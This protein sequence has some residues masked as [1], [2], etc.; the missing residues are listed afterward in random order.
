MPATIPP[1]RIADYFF[2][3]G[4]DALAGPSLDAHRTSTC[5]A[6]DP[7]QQQARASSSP[8]SPDRAYRQSPPVDYPAAVASTSPANTP[9]SPRRDRQRINASIV[10]SANASSGDDSDTPLNVLAP[11]LRSAHG[12][13][14][15]AAQRSRR[16]A[17]KDVSIETSPS[18]LRSLVVDTDNE[19]VVTPA[20]GRMS[21]KHP[22]DY[23]YSPKILN[24]FPAVDY[25]EQEK[26]S[27][28][29]AMLCFPNGLKI[30]H[31]PD[32]MP[33]ATC[34]SF[35]AI[36]SEGYGDKSYG[37]CLVFY[38]KIQ[39]PLAS[40]LDALIE[41]WRLDCI[42]NTDIE[43]LQYLQSQLAINQERLLRAKTGVFRNPE[44]LAEQTEALAEAEEKVH[45][46]R[47]LIK[48]MERVSPIDQE[49]VYVPKCVGILSR[50]PFYDLFA[51]WLKEMFLLVKS[52]NR[53]EV[54]D[55]VPGFMNVPLER[56]LV[57]L[58]YEV[59]LP[60]PG[61]VEVKISI[62]K[63]KFFCSRPPVNSIQVLQNF[64]LYPLF[65]CLSV[66]HI[67]TVFEHAM[68]EKRILFVSKH[69]AML[70]LACESISLLLYPF[71]WQYHYIPVLPAE[72][73]KILQATMPFIIGVNKEYYDK[74]NELDPEWRNEIA[75]VDL[76]NNTVESD[77]DPPQIPPRDRRKLIARLLKYTG[78]HTVCA[79]SPSSAAAP[80]S[81]VAPGY[82]QG[83]QMSNSTASHEQQTQRANSKAS[84]GTTVFELPPKGAPITTTLAFPFGKHV[85]RSAVSR[86][87]LAQIETDHDVR[88]LEQEG[89]SS[90]SASVWDKR[91]ETATS[92]EGVTA[93]DAI[94][95]SDRRGSQMSLPN[96]AKA[97]ATSSSF[98]S[99]PSAVLGT[100][101]VD[102][103][104]SAQPTVGR[105]TKSVGRNLSLNQAASITQRGSLETVKA[106]M[107]KL[108]F[109]LPTR[110]KS[111]V[112]SK[113]A[114]MD[115]D[116]P[117]VDSSEVDSMWSANI[118]PPLPQLLPLQPPADTSADPQKVFEKITHSES[119]NSFLAAVNSVGNQ[120]SVYV[121]DFSA[122]SKAH[123]TTSINSSIATAPTTYY[124][125][126]IAAT[127]TA[128]TNY[129]PPSGSVADFVGTLK[130]RRE[131]P[132]LVEGHAFQVIQ[133]SAAMSSNGTSATSLNHDISQIFVGGKALGKRGS[134][135]TSL[136][137]SRV[138]L[139]KSTSSL[140]QQVIN[141]QQEPPIE[142][143]TVAPNFS[144]STSE[145][146][147]SK[148]VDNDGMTAKESHHLHSKHNVSKQ[149]MPWK[150]ESDER[151][152][153]SK[154]CRLCL[155]DL[156]D[157]GSEPVL[158]CQYCKSTIHQSCLPL[159]EGSPCITYFNERKIQYSFFK[160]FTSLLKTYR[161]FLVMPEK[162][163]LA[164]EKE[165]TGGK[166]SDVNIV[167][168]DLAPDD[169]FRK[170][171]FL[172]SA[173]RE[174]RGYLSHI[175]ETQ[176]F[177]QFTLTRVELPDSDYEIL[178]F[179][180]SIK[181]KMNRSKLK[182]SKDTTPFLKDGAYSIRATVTALPPN[183]DGLETGKNYS[184][185]SFPQNIDTELLCTARKVSPLVTEADQN[186]MRSH[187]NEL[188][189]RTHMTNSKR[190]QDFSKWMRL[191]LKNFQRPENRLNFEM[192]T[193]EQR[194]ALFDEK[195]KSV[196]DAL[197]AY[198][199]THFSSQSNA[200]LQ[201]AIEDLHA[202][203]FLLID[204]TEAELVEADDLQ[205]YKAT[206][207]RLLQVM[208]L[209]KEHLFALENP[210]YRQR[211][212]SSS[213]KRVSAISESER[214]PSV[215]AVSVRSRTE[216]LRKPVSPGCSS[217]GH[218]IPSPSSTRAV[219]APSAVPSGLSPFESIAG[220]FEQLLGNSPE[221]MHAVL[222]PNTL[223]VEPPAG[224]DSNAGPTNVHIICPTGHEDSETVNTSNQGLA[225]RLE[226]MK[227]LAAVTRQRIP[228]IFKQE[229][230]EDDKEQ[231]EPFCLDRN[232]LPSQ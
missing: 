55:G 197:S 124:D 2:H 64:S 112:V 34:H 91:S 168:L 231:A 100:D 117:C 127:T 204:M 92:P 45:L 74:V 104:E 195:L 230:T 200:E 57:N 129:K 207:N 159:I 10:A 37:V 163:R 189:N 145:V 12:E 4:L 220:T 3:I 71:S 227:D 219:R 99:I 76:D 180:E 80:P 8:R 209:Y 150:G 199:S 172:A 120:Q 174:T 75:I 48:T 98:T 131:K 155:E 88:D 183:I 211:S 179:D 182:F 123:Y 126:S 121:S 73:L 136:H 52:I 173:D 119:K 147:L 101:D 47:D 22:I 116:D 19:I 202:K 60:P 95:A 229:E 171:D 169:W 176:N 170:A 93:L 154:V 185:Y 90:P 151:P 222:G 110:V 192:L 16:A 221:K 39:E 206:T 135:A 226:Q 72:G 40:Q 107:A 213:H 223:P 122:K 28:S 62:G 113:T 111:P 1:I 30:V 164:K 218:T 228:A 77:C 49:N 216:S 208:T 84:S 205:E 167:G 162:L 54:N 42:A 224:V 89:E 56:L 188:V 38:E 132:N 217:S 97:C 50:W 212:R 232:A 193:E 25:S 153:D 85:P 210:E 29:V 215:L 7:A 125:P 137:G 32:K 18:H 86:R 196:C 203:Q 11:K 68:A 133:L 118:G 24:R 79:A 165:D 225:H 138:R 69:Y 156:S 61:R 201:A 94:Q 140:T 157:S 59:P 67:V 9:R 194:R 128:G 143:L 148:T 27:D 130:P 160:V 166:S 66:A 35:V 108:R 15:N 105:R 14:T 134:A 144:P 53:K 191:K 23:Q 184:H 187:T 6:S 21:R 181:A 177:V 43:Y 139:S 141:A 13:V 96:S 51:D 161:S 41:S 78:A 178:F 36:A 83:D 103:L 87:W 31:D 20:R 158:K 190:K 26:F 58:L 114:T 70:T 146:I 152:E 63:H 65:R 214:A 81:S 149:L 142:A 17:G 109:A 33:E 106:A 186:M 44:E 102:S 46:F 82:G 5:K 115:D 198:E 175:V